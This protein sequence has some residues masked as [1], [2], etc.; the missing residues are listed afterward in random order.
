VQAFERSC[1]PATLAPCLL[2]PLAPLLADAQ[3]V[4]LTANDELRAIDFHAVD[5]DGAPLLERV[6]VVYALGLPSAS[7]SSPAA[8]RRALVVGDAQGNL[9]A[10]Q[11]EVRSVRDVLEGS[12]IWS[13]VSLT[14]A[15]ARLERVR[16]DM[17]GADLFHYA[18]HARLLG[19]RGWDSELQLGE[20]TALDVGDILALERAPAFVVLSGCETAATDA[21]A[22]AAGIGLAQ[23][24]IAS[25][26]RG[27]VAATR[28]VRDAAALAVMRAFYAAWLGGAAPERALQRAQLALR[29]E[30]PG[31][32]WAAFRL[33]ER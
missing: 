12:G 17:S 19:S 16:R 23:A 5:L 11:E 9:P 27:V 26:S 13:A 7:S 31:A 15:T 2:E 6:P 3:R 32:D 29:S 28:P 8:P 24:F 14:G 33:I 1:A 4:R 18:G 20:R 30:Q 22:E 10:A 25:G 21:R